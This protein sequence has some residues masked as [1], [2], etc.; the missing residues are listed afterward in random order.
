MSLRHFSRRIRVLTAVG[1]VISAVVAAPGLLLLNLG[2]LYAYGGLLFGVVVGAPFVLAIPVAM[3]E[4]LDARASLKRSWFLAKG[5]RLRV[6]PALI[7]AVFAAVLPSA[8]QIIHPTIAHYTLFAQPFF[9][10]FG[11][12]AVG[13]LY[14]NLYDH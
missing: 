3:V 10:V 14:V 5:R 8:T 2:S 13:A 7:F 11:S 9:I 12:I 4:S 1:V 6:L